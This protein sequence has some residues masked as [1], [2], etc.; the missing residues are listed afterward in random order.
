MSGNSQEI[1]FQGL[2]RHFDDRKLQNLY[3]IQYNL[4]F[5]RFPGILDASF[6]D[7]PER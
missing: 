3:S 6:R 1:Y 4:P 2:S 7:E 5:Q